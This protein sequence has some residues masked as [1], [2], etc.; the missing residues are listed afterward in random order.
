MKNTLV[1]GIV[2]GIYIYNEISN[3]T[4]LFLCKMK[5]RYKEVCVYT[6]FHVLL[7]PSS[8]HLCCSAQVDILAVPSGHHSDARSFMEQN[9]LCL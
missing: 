9:K 1:T 6:T 8:S 5:L 2:L 7:P 4:N 3:I